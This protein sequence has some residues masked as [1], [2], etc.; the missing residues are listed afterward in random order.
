ML[1]FNIDDEGDS[2]DYDSEM[3]DFIVGSDVSE[4]SLH[5]SQGGV[6]DEL[7]ED[8]EDEEGEGGERERGGGTQM[9]AVHGTKLLAR[10]ENSLGNGTRRKRRVKRRQRGQCKKQN[11]RRLPQK[12]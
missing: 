4:I 3:D 10:V 7:E 11:R 12:A 6:S 1:G 9:Q 8:E 2:D 5:S